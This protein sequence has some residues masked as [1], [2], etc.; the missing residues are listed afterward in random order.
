MSLL[1][2]VKTG[3]EK[4][5]IL[6]N[7]FWSLNSNCKL[8]ESFNWSF[9]IGRAARAGS[10]R[11]S[12]GCKLLL[13]IFPARIHALLANSRHAADKLLMWLERSLCFVTRFLN[14]SYVT[15]VFGRLMYLIDSAT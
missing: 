4:S 7:D 1:S 10:D 14:N 6:N 3:D 2:R 12:S 5:D 8:N 9:V 11:P 13:L 15:C